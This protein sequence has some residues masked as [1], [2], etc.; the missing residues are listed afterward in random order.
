MAKEDITIEAKDL[1]KWFPVRVGM[2]TTLFGHMKEKYVKAV[3]GV[4][5]RVR[6]GEVIGLAGESGCGK[7]TLGN[8][9]VDTLKPTNGQ[10]LFKGMDIH[11]MKKKDFTHFRRN[12]QMIFQDP[13]GSLNPRFTC[14][15]TVLEPLKIHKIGRADERTEIVLRTFEAVELRPPE[16]FVDM[17]PHQLSGGERQRVAIARA[18]ILEPSFLVADE[19]VSMLDVSTRAGVLGIIKQLIRDKQMTCVY[20]SHDLSL[21]RYAAD[22]TAI[23]YLGRIVEVGKTEDLITNPL[24]P[25]SKALLSAVPV[26]NPHAKRKE[27]EIKGSVPDPINLPP[28][29]RFRPR[30]VHARGACDKEE[31]ELREVDGDRK[32]ACYYLT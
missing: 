21:L 25:Y 16:R 3:D 13:Y 17:L 29:C 4:S 2:M 8:L 5:F 15:K 7:T 19:P 23:M 32:V 6:K 27:P 22:T 1:K 14:F 31:P 11:S 24:H 30:C 26:P 28:G 9:L 12:A 20:I 18:I 10:V